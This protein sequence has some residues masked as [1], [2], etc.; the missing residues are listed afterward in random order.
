M[1]INSDLLG[2]VLEFLDF[3]EVLDNIGDVIEYSKEQSLLTGCRYSLDLI[4]ASI[5]EW[6][7]K[8]AESI[9][10][11]IG[12]FCFR[13]IQDNEREIP[14]RPFG[15]VSSGCRSNTGL[16]IIPQFI[17]RG[18]WRRNNCGGAEK[19]CLNVDVSALEEN[20]LGLVGG[21]SDYLDPFQFPNNIARVFY[22]K[23]A[24]AILFQRL[25]VEG[26]FGRAKDAEKT[27]RL[28]YLLSIRNEFVS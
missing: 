16:D 13:F 26:R 1:V 6:E 28:D 8:F 14:W 20:V 17:Y 5:L 19:F 25:S 10:V 11:S 12:N 4:H 23:C 22:S 15:I 9:N 3:V 2:N 7:D 27:N 24:L 18:R 21:V